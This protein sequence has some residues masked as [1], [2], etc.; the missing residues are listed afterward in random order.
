MW[1]NGPPSSET[2]PIPTLTAL[3]PA[4]INLYLHVVGRRDSGYHELDSLIVFADIHDLVAIESADS[5]GLTLEGPF[6]RALGNDPSNLVLRA[7]QALA[8]QAGLQRGAS[9]TLSK[10]LPVA[11]GIGGGSADAAATLRALNKFWQAGLDDSALSR[12]GQSLGAD[13]PVCIFGRTARVQGIGEHIEPGPELPEIGLLLVNPGVAVSTAAAFSGRAGAFSQ[14][15]DLPGSFDSAASL[16]GFLSHCHNDL[17]DPA[18]RLAPEIDA[19]L[20]DIAR[21]P[22]CLFAALSGSGAT[23]FGIFAKVET[24]SAAAAAL[25][26]VRD[27]WWVQSGKILAATPPA[28]Y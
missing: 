17:L 21:Q 5:L 22:D 27:S 18:R 14:P 19:V 1:K 20:A 9:I 4:K 10:N 7:A 3:A 13:V 2:S 25:Q 6:A 23:G 16:A 28:E 8:D 24:A 11:S 12:L 15:V 26:S